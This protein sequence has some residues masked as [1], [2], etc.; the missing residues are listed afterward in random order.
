[1]AWQQNMER[2]GSIGLALLLLMTL[3]TAGRTASAQPASP[4]FGRYHAVVIGNQSYRHLDELPTARA[5]A[6]EVARLLEERYGFKAE[7]LLD[8][9][10]DRILWTLSQLPSRLTN[11]ER[12]SL[13]IYYVGHGH[14]GRGGA[15]YW[16]PVD[17]DNASDSQWIPTA[18][19]TNIL[20]T[21]RAKHVLVVTDS[22]YA[23][24]LQLPD[25]A[26]LRE[27]REERL[28]RLLD[29]PSLT[30]LTSGSERPEQE[31]GARHSLFA[32]TFLSVLHDNRDVLSGRNLF[33][34]VLQPVYRST[35]KLPRYGHV[36]KNAHEQGDFLLV[37]RHLQE[38]LSRHDVRRPA[39]PPRQLPPAPIPESAPAAVLP[40]PPSVKAAQ[41][42]PKQGD[43]MINEATGM[44]LVYIEGGCFKMG[45][46]AGE[47]GRFAWEGPVHE[48]CVSGFWM[49]RHEVTQEQWEKIM[50]GNPSG[51]KKGGKHP[52]ENVSWN[53]AEE[54][55][56]RLNKRSNGAYRLPTEAEWEYACRAS[57]AG[58]YC[59]GDNP[60]VLAWHEENSSRRT[61]PI[62]GK[63]ANAFGLHD[64]SGNVWEW[65]ADRFDKDYYATGGVRSNPR[66]PS[67]GGERVVRG[68]SAGSRVQNCRAAFRFR[69]Q[70]DYR[71]DLLGFRV[72]M[73]NN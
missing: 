70:P 57:G 50:R 8:A 22:C 68:G 66:G 32:R 7:L 24:S 18:L 10:R 52:V 62:G 44:E 73:Q 40:A 39:P 71:E 31:Y 33:E 72:V 16:K 4:D 25:E 30:V 60:D 63:Q 34:R 43:I 58:K 3:L 5:D 15:G 54:F 67:G 53:D 65:C 38:N 64:M 59:G 51:F 55:F 37:P 21:V 42:Q 11:P 2:H 41:Q 56:T 36:V 12:D 9:D 27:S 45:S 48:V 14:L 47:K 49:G 26:R 23:A 20:K 19:I 6:Q 28:R 46:A 1:M 17:A 29:S 13:L 69:N 35:G 61:H